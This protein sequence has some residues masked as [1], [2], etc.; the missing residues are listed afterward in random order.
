MAAATIVAAATR[1]A[2]ATIVVGATRVVGAARVAVA[3]G[4]QLPAIAT[5]AAGGQQAGV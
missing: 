5:C 3:M 4:S 2:I 1:M